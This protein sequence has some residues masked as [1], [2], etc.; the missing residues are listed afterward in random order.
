M[1]TTTGHRA[2]R[3]D[4]ARSWWSLALIPVAFVA[5]FVVGEGLLALYGY[6]AHGEPAPPGWAIAGAALP[7][8]AVFAVPMV[9]ALRFGRRALLAGDEGAKLPMAIGV[10][11]TTVF[12]LQNTLAYLVGG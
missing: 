8:L 11:V 1:A 2:R 9:L 4:R 3:S 12:V 10:A 5:A 7:A 6:E